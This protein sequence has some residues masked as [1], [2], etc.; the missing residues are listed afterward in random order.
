MGV[1][2][3]KAPH[4]RMLFE[5]GAEIHV[6]NATARATRWTLAA[7]QETSIHRHAYPMW[8]PHTSW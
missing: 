8:C 3:G 7:C 1:P 2:S 6:D 5:V 4:E